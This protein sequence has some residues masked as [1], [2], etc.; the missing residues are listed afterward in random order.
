MGWGRGEVHADPV[1]EIEPDLVGLGPRHGDCGLAASQ[2]LGWEPTSDHLYV[3]AEVI[4][5]GGLQGMPLQASRHLL[6]VDCDGVEGAGR[7]V[8]GD[9]QK[10]AARA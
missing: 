8:P 9:R 4:E 10:H 5:V 6:G 3:L 1:V 7:G 2:P